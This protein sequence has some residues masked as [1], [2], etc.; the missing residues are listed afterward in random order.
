MSPLRSTPHLVA[1]SFGFTGA[2]ASSASA[3]FSRKPARA[4]SP[5]LV[6]KLRRS[7]PSLALFPRRSDHPFPS[8]MPPIDSPGPVSSR[9]PLLLHQQPPNRRCRHLA[10]HRP[11]LLVRTPTPSSFSSSLAVPCRCFSACAATAREHR[12]PLA[13]RR[14][15]ASPAATAVSPFGRPG[16][17]AG[18]SF[19]VAS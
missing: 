19:P 3:P 15:P 7:S 12:C 2:W 16:R 8:L 17:R 11:P 14:R 5:S 13:A 10:L 9:P 1:A 18:L 6:G 4:P